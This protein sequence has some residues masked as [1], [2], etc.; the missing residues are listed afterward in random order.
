MKPQYSIITQDWEHCFNCGGPAQAVHH[1]FFGPLRRIS[2]K[3]G[4]KIPLCHRCHNQ[5]KDAVHFNREKD[6]E[7]KGIAQRAFEALY[8]HIKFMEVIGRNYL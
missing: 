1:V 5:S 8:G 3:W 6:L 2:E 7:Y 4:L